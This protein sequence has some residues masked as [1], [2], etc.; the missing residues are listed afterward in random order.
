[1]KHRPWLRYVHWFGYVASLVVILELLFLGYVGVEEWKR[2]EE[3][4]EETRMQ[5]GPA[6]DRLSGIYAGD[7]EIALLGKLPS[8]PSLEP[9]GFRLVATPSFGDTNFAI[10]LRRT[11]LGGEGVMLMAP[12]RGDSGSVETIPLK[13]SPAAYNEL[14]VRLDAL[15]SSWNGESRSWGDGTPIVFERVRRKSVTSGSGNSPRFYGEVGAAIFEAVRQTTPR[16]AR[17][18]SSWHPRDR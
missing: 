3:R 5:Q 9:D 17:F 11:P 13:L 14:A 2:R 8:P 12:S 4:R 18:D 10:W 6:E 16:L 7:M 15:A 1:M